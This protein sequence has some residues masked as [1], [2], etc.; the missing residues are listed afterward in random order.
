MP[1]VIWSSGNCML[2]VRAR[3]RRGK[4]SRGEVRE[5]EP[6]SER[7][8]WKDREGERGGECVRMLSADSSRPEDHT[9]RPPC[10]L[11]ALFANISAIKHWTE[12]KEII[13][14]IISI[15]I[16]ESSLSRSYWYSG[17]VTFVKSSQTPCSERKLERL[18]S[19]CR[20][21]TKEHSRPIPDGIHCGYASPAFSDTEKA[22]SYR[23]VKLLEVVPVVNL[24]GANARQTRDEG[25]PREV[26]LDPAKALFVPRFVKLNKTKLPHAGNTLSRCP[27]NSRNTR[28]E[29]QRR[30]ANLE[31]EEVRTGRD[32]FLWFNAS[33]LTGGLRSE[34]ER[35][36]EYGS[37]ASNWRMEII[38]ELKTG[39]LGKRR[40]FTALASTL[41]W[42]A[43]YEHDLRYICYSLKSLFFSF[44]HSAPSSSRSSN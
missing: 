37:G 26:T 32:D 28:N 40:R 7:E 42:L 3:K 4:R 31:S 18:S 10:V 15:I 13:A 14:A 36:R 29:E 21:I 11:S 22:I 38:Q 25:V 6:Y 1:R 17:V 8:K 2:Y 24:K 33:V 43:H 19:A 16:H 35:S 9:A 41:T 39:C 27:M 20:A 23:E 34:K 5:E 44:S 30:H 12:K